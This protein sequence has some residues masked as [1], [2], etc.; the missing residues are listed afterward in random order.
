MSLTLR[1]PS[2][3]LESP[4]LPFDVMITRMSSSRILRSF[5]VH[6]AGKLCVAVLL[7]AIGAVA[8]P[9]LAQS[10]ADDILT[11]VRA[12]LKKKTGLPLD[13]RTKAEQ[14]ETYYSR[15]DAKILWSDPARCDEMMALLPALSTVVPFNT[16][17]TL[18]RLEVR[19]QALRSQDASLLALVELTFSAQLFDVAQSLRLGQMALYRDKL[20]RRSLERFIYADRLLSRVAEGKPLQAILDGIEPQQKDYLAIRS[21]L[22]QY[23]E[24]YRRGG[25]VALHPGPD[26]KESVSD[27]RVQ[28][29]RERLAITGHL[30][31]APGTGD[32]YDAALAEAVRRFQKE[33]GLAPNGT[34]DRRTLLALNV[35]VQDRIAQLTANLERW[36]WFD[37][38]S[39]GEYWVISTNSARI[40]V[41]LASGAREQ[42]KIRSDN[43]CLQ[44]HALDSIIEAVEINPSYAFPQIM[45]AKYVLPVLQSNPAALGPGFAIY[46]G[47]SPEIASPVDWRSYSE[48]NFPFS[49]VQ[50]PGPANV[51]GAFR[52]P[53]RDEAAVSLHSHP[54]ADVKQPLPRSVW[55][56]CVDIAAPTG[57]VAALLA[58]AGLLGSPDAGASGGQET[59]RIALPAPIPVIFIYETVWLDGDGAVVFGPDPLGLDA[60][61][62]RKLKSQRGK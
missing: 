48:A 22:V 26:L 17:Q 5:R 52:M 25:W 50:K 60:E 23:N 29:L 9:E 61:L 15:K 32:R 57:R 39:P 3:L 27:P 43:A 21:K 62:A 55:P 30:T 11:D 54:E 40:D 20:H 4:Q 45:S 1:V 14:L 42:V 36:R 33:H 53:L 35:P 2:P 10:E 56:R 41:R 19:K 24:I 18:R 6:L 58:D 13:V 7:A 44:S 47:N 28:A 12:S 59:Q 37:D 38:V 49:V 51:L 31:S 34:L 46:P 8:K 16:E